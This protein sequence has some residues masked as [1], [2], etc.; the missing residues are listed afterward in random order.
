MSKI[1]ICRSNSKKVTTRRIKYLNS[2]VAVQLK[3][4]II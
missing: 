3:L 1:N 4:Q 2:Q